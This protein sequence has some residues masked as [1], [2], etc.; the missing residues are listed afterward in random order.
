MWLQQV[1]KKS[2]KE[3]VTKMSEEKDEIKV[4]VKRQLLK[5]IKEKFPEARGLTNASTVDWAL[6]VLLKF[7]EAGYL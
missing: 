5:E 6:R 1:D 7:K 3:S 4:R 2:S